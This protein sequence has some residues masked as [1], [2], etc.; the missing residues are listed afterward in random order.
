MF[1]FFFV[2]SKCVCKLKKKVCLYSFSIMWHI[3]DLIK[4]VG[5]DSRQNSG[6]VSLIYKTYR[7]K[8]YSFI[9][10]DVRLF[11]ISIL[12]E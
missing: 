12:I 5:Y 2:C 10:L 11:S 1:V 7:Q 9:R 8:Y 3:S 6:Y 4:I